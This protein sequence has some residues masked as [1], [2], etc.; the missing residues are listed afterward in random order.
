MLLAHGSVAGWLSPALSVLLSAEETPLTT[1]PL[2]NHEVSWL[3]GISSLGSIVG[4]F[5]FGFLASYLGCKRAMSYLALPSISF[6]LLV[7]FGDTLHHLLTGRFIMG[8]TAG[9]IQ[10]GIIIFI[11]EI[12]NNKLVYRVCELIDSAF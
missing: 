12:S 8:L 7:F 11:S 1:G 2:S 5:I 3:G 9:G 10:S 4:T 6:W